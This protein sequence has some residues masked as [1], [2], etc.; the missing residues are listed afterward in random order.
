MTDIE[1]LADLDNLYAS[2]KKATEGT[3]WKC[4]VQ[5][6]GVDALLNLNRLS[7][8]ILA[9]KYKVHYGRQFDINER[10]KIRHITPLS[11]EDRIVQRCLCDYILLQRIRPHL[12]YDNGAC[13]TGKGVS[14]AR[15]RLVQHLAYHWRQ[16]KG[17]G[18]ILLCDIHNYFGSLDQEK[19][20]NM[21]KAY[22][23]TTV[24]DILADAVKTPTGIGVGIGSQVSQVLGLLYLNTLD[25][26]IKTK[27]QFKCYGRFNDDFYIIY[28]DK[29]TLHKTLGAI[30]DICTALGLVINKNKTQVVK[31][32]HGFTFMKT[33]YSFSPTGKIVKRL[34]NCNIVRERRR[35]KKLP[36]KISKQD[37]AHAWKAWKCNN[38]KNYNCHYTTGRLNKIYYKELTN[39][40][41]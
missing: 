36:R 31:L 3:D 38:E 35:L 22:A 16:H 6:Y 11:F 28:Y 37:Y 18:Y 33:Q 1:I 5:R 12:I 2:Y 17:E 39:Y 8:K 9:G 29:G 25:H 21:L 4:S 14:F 27:K 41:Y 20:L 15:K 26:Y 13:L 34:S 30:E 40:G 23:D 32:K 7:E 10:G 24:H 19:A